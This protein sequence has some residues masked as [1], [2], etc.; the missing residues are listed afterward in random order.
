MSKTNSFKTLQEKWYRKL[1]KTKSKEYP[2]G[3]Q[4][5][6]KNEYEFKKPHLSVTDKRFFKSWKIK[7]EYYSMA[8]KFLHDYK[9]KNNRERIIW[10]YHA[11]GISIRGIVKLLRGVRVGVN[12]GNINRTLIRLREDM[13]KMYMH[14]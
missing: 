12:R 4:D 1:A 9:F 3:F 6:E 8:G 11:N 14:E 13:K 7:L 10:E 5:L 2:N